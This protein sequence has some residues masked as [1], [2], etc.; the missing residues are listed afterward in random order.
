[1]YAIF[2]ALGHQFKVQ[3]GDK[4]KLPLMDAERR[5]SPTSTS[6]G[7]MITAPAARRIQIGGTI[8]ATSSP[9]ATAIAEVATSASA[10]PAK[11]IHRDFPKC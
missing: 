10:D 4:L 9:P 5:T 11:T 8:R 2:K 1:M 6:S 7:S 3:K